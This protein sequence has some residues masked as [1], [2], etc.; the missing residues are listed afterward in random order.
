MKEKLTVCLGQVLSVDFVVVT[1]KTQNCKTFARGAKTIGLGSTF[2]E[3]LL[4]DLC[5]WMVV[6]G[7]LVDDEFVTRYTPGTGTWKVAT[8][9]ELRFAGKS[10]RSLCG[11]VLRNTW[12]SVGSRER[13]DMLSRGVC[14][15]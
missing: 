3:L 1:G 8:A 10:I 6:G 13:E 14:S 12:H 4:E 11:R 2:E 7:V 15:V 5:D 9:K